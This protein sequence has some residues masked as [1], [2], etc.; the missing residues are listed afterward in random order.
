MRASLHQWART[1]SWSRALARDDQLIWLD[2]SVVWM[3]LLINKETKQTNIGSAHQ[4]GG[5]HQSD[6][7]LSGQW[8]GCLVRIEDRALPICFVQDKRTVSCL[9]FKRLWS[10]G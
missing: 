9:F 3:A 1:C 8:K 5:K 6:K 10:K 7:R 2:H 4:I